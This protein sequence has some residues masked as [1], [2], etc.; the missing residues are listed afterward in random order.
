MRRRRVDIL[1]DDIKETVKE[2]SKG[3]LGFL[4]RILLNNI[5]AA[6]L[7]MLVAKGWISDPDGFN[8]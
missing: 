7:A 1:H 8:E 5:V 4:V 3:V 2:Q 6:L